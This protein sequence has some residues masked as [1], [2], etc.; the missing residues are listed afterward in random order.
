MGS[1]PA[2]PVRIDTRLS[3]QIHRYHTWPIIGYQTIAEHC[4]NLIRIYYSVVGSKYID[5]NMIHHMM[6]HDIGETY[7]GDVPYP[8]K[9]ENPRLKSEMDFLENKSYCAQLQYWDSF[10]EILLTERD[11]ILF[12]QIELT[13]M[14]E[15]GL[16]QVL[17]GNNHGMIIADRCLKFVYENKPCN[18]LIDY[19]IKRIKLFEIQCHN[20]LYGTDVTMHPWW[21]PLKWEEL[22]NGHETHGV[23]AG[24]SK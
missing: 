19:V 8:L 7:V 3:G 2:E 16:G 20:P 9:K 21:F 15:F 24:D 17:L 12:K 4:W 13:E 10:D 18:R 22:K 1:D 23:S 14:A 5:P 6:F 11:R